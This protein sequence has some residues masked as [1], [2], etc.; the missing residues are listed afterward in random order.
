MVDRRRGRVDDLR[1][2][3]AW[4]HVFG[5]MTP[6]DPVP[7]LVVDIARAEDLAAFTV[8]GYG[9]ELVTGDSPAIRPTGDGAR[10][11]FE[12][13]YQHLGE[14]AVYD[15]EAGETAPPDRS[16]S[17]GGAIPDAPQPPEPNDT[18]PSQPELAIPAKRS[19]LVFALPEGDEIPFTVADVLA[20]MGRLPMVVHPLATPRATRASLPMSV[21][22]LAVPGGFEA[23]LSRSGLVITPARGTPITPSGVAGMMRARRDLRRVNEILATTAGIYA[24]AGDEAPPQLGRDHVFVG[25]HLPP[26]V[27]RRPTLSRP[28]EPLETA[29]EAPFRLQI[30][31]SEQGG[32]AH[33]T[34]PVRDPDSPHRVELWHSRLGVREDGATGA[35]DEGAAGQRIIRA[36]WARDREAMPDW[37]QRR[38]AVHANFPFRMSLDPD[39]RHILVRQ[40]AE[41]WLDSK[42]SPISPEPVDVNSLYVSSLGAWLDV[43]GLWDTD[44]YTSWEEGD[45]SSAMAAI[46]S[47]DHIA[48]MG[49]DQ[50]VRVT[51]P[52]YLYPVGP[53]A[54]L[55]KLTERKMKKAAPSLA[56]L[57]QKKF[58]IV[59]EPVV[60]FD[61]TRF[62]FREVRLAPL[63]TPTLFPDPGA[64]QNK[65]FFPMVANQRFHFVLHCT[66]WEGRKVRLRAQLMWVSDSYHDYADIDGTYATDPARFVAASGQDVAY[67]EPTKSGDTT[68]PTNQIQLGGAARNHGSNPKLVDAVVEL[69]AVQQLSAVGPVTIKYPDAFTGFGGG[70]VGEVWA[71]VKDAGKELAFGGNGAGS[72]K[73]GGFIQPNLKIGGLSRVKGV[74]GDPVQ[75]ALGAFDPTDILASIALPKLFGIVELTDILE[76]VGLDGAPSV[77]SEAL[78]RIES[79]MLDLERLEQV[80]QDAVDEAIAEV[81]RAQAKVVDG[82]GQE[83]VDAAEQARAQVEALQQLVAGNP[84]GSGAAGAVIA[85]IESLTASSEIADV[86]DALDQPT[87]DLSAAAAQI[88]TVAP[89]LPPLVRQQLLSMAAVLDELATAVDLFE[90]VLAF[91]KGFATSGIQATYRFEWKPEMKSWPSNATPILQLEKDSFVLAVEGRAAGNDGMKVDVLAELRDFE[92][93]LLPDEPLVRFRFDHISFHAGSS[94]K[95]EVDVVLQDI[96]FLGILG[97]IERLK[98]LIPFDGFS[99]PPYLD[100]SAE[101]ITAGFTLALPSVAVGVFNLSNISLGA[102][103]R[104]PFLGEAVTVGFNFCTRE[105]PFTLA[106]LFIGGGGW[107]MLRLSPDGLDLLEVGLEA[108]AVLSVDFGVASGSVSAMLGIYMRLEG[109]GGSLAGYFRLRGEVDVLGLI[110]ASIELYLE[111]LYDFATGKMVGSASLT[112]KVEV[113]MFSMSVTIR[114]ERRFAGSNGDPD[115]VDVMGLEAD[116]SSPAWSEYCLAFAGA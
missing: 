90:D 45:P 87:T 100:V 50:Y 13:A 46:L 113:F 106:V 98:D 49:R 115:F 110:S 108:G 41:T 3:A 24:S 88:K 16:D 75:A 114:T 23:V 83:L 48:P 99:D 69:P 43:H 12:L 6:P 34:G 82:V 81:E 95:P 68:V 20:A 32:W 78:D 5:P 79:F 9:V 61:D 8:S 58:L 15:V 44:P 89:L 109:D 63:V 74:I 19:R 91:V 28:P 107:C 2:G 60:R 54:T 27:R 85:A 65:H 102:D 21:P 35:V 33:S 53:K 31:P 29:I 66:D 36:I 51:Y 116:G 18:A 86:I 70:N 4:R 10:L 93:L 25:P 22:R 72:D 39:D 105:R 38:D 17:P 96:E 80:V 103:V 67:A 77:V 59:N 112:V 84:P 71:E 76:A 73:A 7:D 92:L 104:V 55:V 47:W 11:V 97:F 37:E 26:R 40:S 94:G 30:S 1:F 111:L 42:N 52:G 56:A 101:G 57:Y 62:P 14:R 64:G